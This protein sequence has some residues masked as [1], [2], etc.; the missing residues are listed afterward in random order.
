M[1]INL[2]DIELLLFISISPHDFKYCNKI[3]INMGEGTPKGI[4][5]K[6]EEEDNDS[7]VLILFSII[8]GVKNDFFVVF[9]LFNF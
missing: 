5:F 8:G 2:F 3:S 6:Y 9:N 4:K 7:C 1:D